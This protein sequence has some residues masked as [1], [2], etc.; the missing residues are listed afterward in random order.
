MYNQNPAHHHSGHEHADVINSLIECAFACESCTV[1]C[2]EVKDVSLMAYCIELSRDCA[3]ICLLGAKLL[4]RDSKVTDGFLM[5]CE[6]ACRLCAEE[7]S[8]HHEYE[9]CKACAIACFSCQEACHLE[10]EK[11]T[12]R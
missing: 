10:H 2:L 8:L 9:P 7:C 11:V 12:L 3:E 6:E 4:R 1:A 5:V